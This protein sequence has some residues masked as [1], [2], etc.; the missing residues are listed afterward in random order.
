MVQI[1]AR[2][3]MQT[4]NN[5]SP[6]MSGDLGLWMLTSLHVAARH[7]L[8]AC[9]VEA[10]HTRDAHVVLHRHFLHLSFA[11]FYLSRLVLNLGLT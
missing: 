6:F 9:K 11:L 8:E 1:T 2:Q 3:H 5:A 7:C 10:G 4:Y